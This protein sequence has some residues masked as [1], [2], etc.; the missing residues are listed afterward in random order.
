MSFNLAIGLRSSVGQLNISES[1]GSR[2]DSNDTMPYGRASNASCP[3]KIDDLHNKI[4]S[5]CDTYKG[6]Q[7]QQFPSLPYIHK[8]RQKKRNSHE[9]KRPKVSILPFKT[10]RKYSLPKIHIKK[11]VENFEEDILGGDNTE[12]GDDNEDLEED[13]V[14]RRHGPGRVS[15]KNKIQ[16]FL[17][18]IGY[19][20]GLP[21]VWR[22][23]YLC[24]DNWGGAFF[25]P[26]IIML[27]I[28][29]F[30]LLY[31]ELAIGQLAQAGPIIAIWKFSPLFKGLGIASVMIAFVVGLYNIVI[32]TWSLFYVFKSFGSTLPW[33]TC[34]NKWNTKSCYSLD[35]SV[36][37][38]KYE[39]LNMTVPSTQEFFEKRV[40]AVT[41][42]N[43]KY[44]YIQWELAILLFLAW[45]IV[46][47]GIRRG[48][49][50]IGKAFYLTAT[51][52]FLV[53]IILL[54][55]SAMLPGAYLGMNYL[56]KP[57]LSKL[58]VPEIWILGATQ[59]FYSLGISFGSLI[60]LASYNDEN[61]NIFRDS[62][63]MSLSSSLIS[64]IVMITTYCVIGHIAYINNHD[65]EEAITQG[66]GLVFVVYPQVFLTL[67]YTQIWAFLYFLMMICLGLDRQFA[68]VE[69]VVTSFYDVKLFDKYLPGRQSLVLIACIISYLIGLVFLARIIMFFHVAK[70]T[71]IRYDDIYN[72][73]KW[74]TGLGWFLAF[75]PIIS[76]MSGFIIRVYPTKDMT[77][78]QRY[79]NTFDSVMSVE[80]ISISRHC[81]IK[82]PKTLRPL[83][84]NL[85]FQE[86]SVP[87][88]K[89]LVPQQNHKRSEYRRLN[90]NFS[91][92]HYHNK[93]ES[94]KHE[95]SPACDPEEFVLRFM[96]DVRKL[97]AAEKL[98]LTKDI[99]NNA[100]SLYDKSLKL[101][102]ESCSKPN[103]TCI[104]KYQ[105]NINLKH[106]NMHI[107]VNKNIIQNQTKKEVEVKDVD[108]VELLDNKSD[109]FKNKI[110]EKF[111]E[112][113]HYLLNRKFGRKD[114][115]N[116]PTMISKFYSVSN[117]LFAVGLN[118][119]HNKYTPQYPGIIYQSFLTKDNIHHMLTKKKK[120]RILISK[121]N[122]EDKT[123]KETVV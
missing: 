37:N 96:P 112:D 123:H 107:N 113:H 85:F 44:K 42:D 34:L 48:V 40:L 11:L 121:D 95:A 88:T 93:K 61:N 78:T 67:P 49:K 75:M 28:C 56:I 90:N 35:L 122:N 43:D 111:S 118:E 86:P 81:E 109:I 33:S 69:V 39:R 14:K 25:I 84:F 105:R 53:V 38:A 1:N 58:L 70:H 47:F 15:W 18:F 16:L 13:P 102:I 114:L 117:C 63:V 17:A 79:K 32:V 60:A 46:F 98:K 30:P 92:R 20:M 8:Y 110:F 10:P 23:P 89:E 50:S 83:M 104:C 41:N 36:P 106:N 54:I 101:N 71:P 62:I 59:S 120:C 108:N 7:S 116:E 5:S 82:E 57:D 3:S 22:F 99:P 4:P 27:L 73:P 12:Y 66:P 45:V 119:P 91:L 76:V 72:Y 24:Y 74:A 21:N 77:M 19:S 29:G 51:V 115:K 6:T 31:L 103:H 97:L 80:A 55:K 2:R 52:P 9:I 26:Y 100:I 65:I 87:L 64:I 68:M 94:I